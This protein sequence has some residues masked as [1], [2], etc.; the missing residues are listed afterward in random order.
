MASEASE[1]INAEAYS[2][3]IVIILTVGFSLACIFGYFSQKMKFSPILGYLLAGYIIG[4][5]FPGFVADLRI[6]E[7]LAEI[8][9]I[10]MMFGVGLHFKWQDL[11]KVKSIAIP[12]AIGQTFVASTIAALLIHSI[13]WSW[14][15]GVIIG[16]SIGVASTVV[17]V[18]VLSDNQ[19][20]SSPQGHIAVGWLIVEDILTVGALVL[21]PTIV[22]FLNGTTISYS[23]VAG[24]VFF[25]L[26]KFLLLA[27]VMFTLGR[28]I[29]SYVLFQ[30]AR[31]RLPELFTLAVLSLTFLIAVGSSYLFGTSIALG[32][33]V[34]GMVIGQTSVRHQASAH[35]SSMKDAFVVIFF[36]SVGMLFNPHAIVGHF[37]LF[38]SVLGI[39][40]IIKPLTAFLIVILLRYPVSTAL[41]IA[42]A[43]AQIG[44]FSFILA[45]AAVKLEI[46]PDVGY[47]IIVA[48]ALVSISINPLLFRWISKY[49]VYRDRNEW[50]SQKQGDFNQ[51]SNATSKA[52]VIGFGSIGQNITHTLERLGF[53]PVVI[54]RN[55]DTI[56]KLLEENH[57]AVYGDASCPTMLE[58]MNVETVNLMVI[59]TSDVIPALNII[60]T[61]RRLQ[62]SITILAHTLHAEDQQL[63][64]E[65]GVNFICCDEL[66]VSKALNSALTEL[67]SVNVPA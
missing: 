39:I 60:K 44:E 3:E 18:R 7:Q 34:A 61:A 37:P 4:P 46:L 56:V 1:I 59:T 57:E 21:L 67:R 51:V 43:L 64:A 55:I 2:L 48:C 40:L 31:T 45:E 12:G 29:V 32:A 22:A 49:N 9:V 54:D 30:I 25:V 15:S 10:L 28:K 6:S 41:T 53:T 17:L 52:L 19:I 35:A 36:L 62:P 38:I 27:A 66:E 23:E 13:G 20:L 63:F 58:M 8:G 11:V 33:F 14:A 42:I 26:F 65:L 5:Y 50:R 24:S 16:L 47:D